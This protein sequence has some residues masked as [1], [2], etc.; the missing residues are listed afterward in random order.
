MKILSLWPP[1][2]PS[3]F[4]AGHHL[5]VF[6]TAAYLRGQG[7]EVKAIDAGALNMDWKRF[8]DTAYQGRYDLVAIVNDFD[9]TDDFDR[10]VRY[11]R[12]L[13]P[14]TSIVTA[15]RLSVEAPA[16]FESTDVDGIVTSGD[17]ESGVA[18][19][20]S[21]LGRGSDIGEIPPG[22]TVRHDCRWLRSARPG[23]LLPAAEWCLPDTSEIPYAAYGR[24][25]QRDESKFCGIPDRRELVVPAARGCPIGCSYCDVPGVQGVKDRRLTVERTV[26]YI[27][28]SFDRE[29]FE[30]V[31]FY[32]PTF[33]LNRRWTREL[34]TALR[35]EG[36]PYPWKCAT[37]ISHLPLDLLEDMAAA[38]C[39]RV[40]VGLETLEP[41]GQ[42]NLPPQ[43]HISFGRFQE[44]ADACTRLGVELNCFVIAG[45][46]GTT[47]LGVER[48]VAEIRSV[49]GRTRPTMYA[50][51]EEL[52]RA[53]TLEDAALYNRHL[54]HP[55]DADEQDLHE[56][57]FGEEKHITEVMQSV[58]QRTWPTGHPLR[59]RKPPTAQPN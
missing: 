20:A 44:L 33:T 6:L 26:A 13:S 50:N 54:L 9:N 19:F 43:K 34:C 42:G 45:L 32:A 28:E 2:V 17:P 51:I 37:A 11:I 48:T 4:N 31:A 58:P 1:Q 53:T 49:G 7:H 27:K 5:P 56:L 14:Q 55:F 22:L 47:P 25:Y 10:T 52:R 35:A 30:Y 24:M 23:T 29:P 57:V 12:R 21:W 40:S 38:R 46:P 8:A 36:S 59:P 18:S 41:D 16:V 39:V 3:Y 15:G